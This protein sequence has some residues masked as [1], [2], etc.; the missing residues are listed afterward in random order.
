M[1]V[2]RSALQQL[3][4]EDW[5]WSL[6]HYPEFATYLGDARYNDRLTDLSPEAIERAKA[7]EREMLARIQNIDR[8]ALSGQDVISYDL[9]LLDKQRNVEGQQFPLELMPV[10]QMEGPQIS[11]GQLVASM[12][13]EAP[14][15]YLNY[16]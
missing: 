6:Q 7:H 16:I 2:G 5:E 14:Q 15:D 9:F 10:S 12:P 8:K 11:F 1:P 13:F 4:A 3:F